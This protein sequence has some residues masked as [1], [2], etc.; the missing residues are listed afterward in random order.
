MLSIPGKEVSDS[1]LG[2]VH[3]DIFRS[4]GVKLLYLGGVCKWVS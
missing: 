3:F 2:L 1:C 4:S